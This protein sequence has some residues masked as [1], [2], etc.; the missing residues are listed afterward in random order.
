MPQK[1]HET[2]DNRGSVGSA[3]TP[4]V[5]V[6]ARISVEKI[7]TET[8]RV[9]LVIDVKFGG[10][11]DSLVHRDDLPRNTDLWPKGGAPAADI[12]AHD[13]E[14]LTVEESADI[15]HIGRDKVYYL[16]RTGE[17]RSIKIGKLRRISRAWVEE[18]VQRLAT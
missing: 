10:D 3:S 4:G 9:T 7:N 17:L 15:L 18:F 11:L 1:D 13:Q 2:F 6:T 5:I 8:V 12:T 16:I 14:L